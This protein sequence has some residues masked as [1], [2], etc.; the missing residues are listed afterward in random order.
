M[1]VACCIFG[2]VPAAAQLKA[3]DDLARLAGSARAQQAPVLIAFMQKTCPYCAVARSDFLVPMQNDPRWRNRVL[4]REIDVDRSTSMR[5]FEGK[6]TTHADFARSLGVRR[7]PT[8]IV[9]DAAGSPAAP[10]IIGLL[11]DDF[12]SLYIEQAVEAGLLK[13]RKR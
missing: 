9:F 7:V 8:L 13:M 3:A 5:D 1:I 2:A 12:Y 6:P 11:N 10:P 4:I